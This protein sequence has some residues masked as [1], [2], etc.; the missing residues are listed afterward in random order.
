MRG[1][2]EGSI[3]TVGAEESNPQRGTNAV[4]FGRIPARD[5]G[6]LTGAGRADR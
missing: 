3:L 2:E 1:G 6:D 5:V 4:L